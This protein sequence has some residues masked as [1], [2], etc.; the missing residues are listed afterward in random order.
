[1]NPNI[2]VLTDA[3]AKVLKGKNVVIV[4]SS[5]LST[6]LSYDQASLADKNTLHHIKNFDVNFPFKRISE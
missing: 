2:K 1:M 4:A 5:N 6:N 3:L